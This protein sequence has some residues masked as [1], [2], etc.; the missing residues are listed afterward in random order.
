[1]KVVPILYFSDVLCVWAYIAQ[2]R[3]DYVTAQFGA[4]VRIE[5]RFCSIFADTPGKIAKS[6]NGSYER[7]NAHLRHV[8]G[9]FPEVDLNPDI[10]IAARPASSTSPHLFLKAAGLAEKTGALDAGAA[11]RLTWAMRCAFFREGR[12]IADADVQHDVAQGQG[13]DP[14]EIHRRIQDGSAFAALAA[15][16]AE[17]DSLGVRGSPSFVLNEGRQKLYG[18]VGY[19]IIEA[20]IEE[21]L[22]EPMAGEASWC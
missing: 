4:Q 3:L 20:N 5:A 12:D 18:N 10:W 7:F 8:A 1:M 19:R 17:A 15:D 14:S 9:S 22:R 16:Y 2:L 13:V 11:D 6:W 21:L